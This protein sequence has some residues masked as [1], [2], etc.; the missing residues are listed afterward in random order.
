MNIQ[1]PFIAACGI[2]CKKC[3]IYKSSSD[4]LLAKSLADW[5]HTVRKIDVDPVEIKCQGCMGSRTSHWSPDCWILKCCVDTKGLKH[6]NEC[7]EFPCE[8]LEKWAKSDIG[9]MRALE[10]LKSLNKN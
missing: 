10:Y 3:D 2:D 7:N 9:Y 4:L 1:N 5:F 6:C 8:R